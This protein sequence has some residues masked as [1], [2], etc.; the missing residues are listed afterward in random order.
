M[1]NFTELIQEEEVDPATMLA[2]EKGLY[3]GATF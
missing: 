1:F 3:F 2:E